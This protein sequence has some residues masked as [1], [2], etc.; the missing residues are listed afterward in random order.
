ALENGDDD[1]RDYLGGLQ[2][3]PFAPSVV[4]QRPVQSTLGQPKSTVEDAEKRVQAK[5]ESKGADARA[6]P[7]PKG[8][9]ERPEVGEMEEFVPAYLLR[10]LIPASLLQSHDFWQNTGPSCRLV[11]YGKEEIVVELLPRATIQGVGMEGPFDSTDEPAASARI[12][13]SLAS[14]EGGEVEPHLLLNMMTAP[15]GTPLHSVA[16]W[17]TRLD[18]L[19]HVLAWGRCSE[20]DKSKPTWASAPLRVLQFTRLGLTFFIQGEEGKQRLVSADFGNLSVPQAP[21]AEQVAKLLAG[22]PHSVVLC[23][24]MQA[25]HVLVPQ[26]LPVR[27]AVKGRPFTTDI[28]FEKLN[29]F[30][31]QWSSKAKV[32]Y[33]K[34]EVHVS[35]GF[36]IAPSF[37][38]A[39]YL[40]LLR[41]LARDYAGVC[42]L[43][44]A[45]GTDAELNDEEAQILQVLGL[46][47]D[48]H[49]DALACRCL[50]TL[51]VMRSPAD[52][53]V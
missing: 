23:D 39:M 41:F 42:S 48:S 49:P 8:A 40:L 9:W 5:L 34:Y 45:V 32:T 18:D 38:S 12:T 31:K 20:A 33:F 7:K 19:A 30:G 36:L 16:R 51:A 46:V 17:A 44:H 43:V 4:I 52:E 25:L 22:V 37:S 1:Y 24:E 13:M 3:P 14:S 47:E 53:F 21:I 6:P 28:V 26:A 2:P 27:P 35:K 29:K 10:G 15:K 11:G 50:I